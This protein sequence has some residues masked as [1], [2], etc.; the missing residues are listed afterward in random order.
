MLRRFTFVTLRKKSPLK[1]SGQLDR[2]T[3][4]SPAAATRLDRSAC[5]AA[6]A[7]RAA[8]TGVR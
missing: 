3:A 7:T 1:H 6:A 8:A 4:R 2:C 5:S